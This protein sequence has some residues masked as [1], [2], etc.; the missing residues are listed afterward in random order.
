M[1]LIFQ[2]KRKK[3][4]N[5]IKRKKKIIEQTSELFKNAWFN[6]YRTF[7]QEKTKFDNSFKSIKIEQIH[8]TMQKIAEK[9]YSFKQKLNYNILKEEIEKLRFLREV[10]LKLGLK[11]NNPHIRFSLPDSDSLFRI[12]LKLEDVSEIGV[13]I[14]SID[15]S[16]E[17]IKLNL[18]AVDRD[19]KKKEFPKALSALKTYLPVALNIYGHFHNDVILILNKI[20]ICFAYMKDI[21]SGLNYQTIA[22][23]LSLKVNGPHNKISLY[24]MKCIVNYI[25]E[26]GDIDNCINMHVHYLKSL[27][28]VGGRYNPLS[29]ECL[30]Q[31]YSLAS[32]TK[33]LDLSESVL[34][35]LENRTSCLYGKGDQRNLNWLSRL[36]F[37]KSQKGDFQTAKELQSKNSFILKQMIKKQEE[38][39]KEYSQENNKEQNNEENEKNE[40]DKKTY[41]FEYYKLNLEKK[42]EESEKMKAFFDNKLKNNKN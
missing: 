10:F 35:E 2:K 12:P 6:N 42:F 26:I 32:Q 37:T 14:K 27:D 4:K 30:T 17:E 3:R 5:K 29:I 40:K 8:S 11:L 39:E 22:Y 7:T 18:M 15:F 16:F 25:Y 13:K 19:L 36:A 23:L 38:I 9:K 41:Y 33:N 20:G 34:I 31:I 28:I 21:N 24:I 1:K